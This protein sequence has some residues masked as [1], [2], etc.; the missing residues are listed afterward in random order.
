MKAVGHVVAILSLL[1]GVAQL[2]H[3]V[4]GVGVGPVDIPGDV[5]ADLFDRPSVERPTD[6]PSTPT[7]GFTDEEL[8]AFADQFEDLK[9]RFGS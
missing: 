8:D 5:Y 9:E 3:S 1:V 7:V 6:V 4:A 2:A